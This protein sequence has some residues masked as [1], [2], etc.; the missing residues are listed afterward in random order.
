M[1]LAKSIGL[2]TPN[3]IGVA[4]T[5]AAGLCFITNDSLVKHVSDTLASA[6][7]I[8]IRG[9][10]AV[11]LLF[12][13]GWFY[14][15][16]RDFRAVLMPVVWRR[17]VVDAVA[18]LAYLTSIAHL[19]IGNATAINMASPIFIAMGAAL[20]FR[21][22]V[23]PRRWLLIAV[24]FAGVM[25]IVQPRASGFNAY[26]L[27]ALAATLLHATRDL[28]TR[29]IPAQVPSYLVTLTTAAVVTIFSGM[30]S[31]YQGW[32]PLTTGAVSTMALS[33]VVLSGGYFLIIKS[34]RTGDMSLIAPFRYSGLPFALL[35][36]DVFWGDVPNALAWLGIALLVGAGILM[37][38]G[39]G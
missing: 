30:Y 7:L 12:L 4:A 6:Q 15:G 1:N 33:S 3:R 24:G 34:M 39:K 21:E 29:T 11:S 26:A 25:M 38:R 5:I 27:L 18:A 37:V 17:A 32:R 13:L 23:S 9:L 16:Q 14:L 28:M 36:G 8:F 19:P 20:W 2:N 31:V 22:A 35:I 10:F